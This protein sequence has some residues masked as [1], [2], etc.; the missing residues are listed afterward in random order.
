[1]DSNPVCWINYGD[2]EDADPVMQYVTSLYWAF[3]TMITVGYGD[4]TPKT[5]GERMYTMVAMIIASGM[6]SYTLNSIGNIVSRY[7]ILAQNYHEKMNYVN[8]FL[9]QQQLPYDLRLKIRRYLEYMW[10]HKKLIKIDEKEVMAMLN[11]SLREK[12]TVYLN[13]RIL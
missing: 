9:I 6:F 7:N 2:F 4:I 5:T 11:E 3:T 12:I 10:E 13:G 1:M 8:K